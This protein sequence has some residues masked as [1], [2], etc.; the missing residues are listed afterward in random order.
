MGKTKKNSQKQKESQEGYMTWKEFAEDWLKFCKKEGIPTHIIGGPD[1][2]S[3]ET[4]NQEQQ[5]PMETFH[6]VFHQQKDR[7]MPPKK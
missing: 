4:P 2:S 7:T 5:E 6:V 1:S 3:S